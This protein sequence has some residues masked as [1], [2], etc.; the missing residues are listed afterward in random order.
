ML[1][2]GDGLPTTGDLDATALRATITGRNYKSSQCQADCEGTQITWICKASGLFWSIL[3]MFLL[4]II[5]GF[6]YAYIA[7][8]KFK[9]YYFITS[10]SDEKSHIPGKVAQSISKEF[11]SMK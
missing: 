2:L 4:F 1:Y 6:W 11:K 8:K 3:V 10:K 9:K 7:V 5:S